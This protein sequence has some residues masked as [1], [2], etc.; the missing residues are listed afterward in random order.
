MAGN[1]TIR[2]NGGADWLEGSDG[3]DTID[4]G[5]GNDR[6]FGGYGNDVLTGGSGADRFA[7]R[8]SEYGQDRVTDF[9]FA[10][11]DRIDFGEHASVNGYA[12]LS[13]ASSPGGAII[14]YATSSG[15]SSITLDG[16]SVAS[17]TQEW[18]AF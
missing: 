13:I 15:Q 9:S 17:I 16:V 1:D 8:D 11:G 10:S 2:G 6:I 3:I 14:R 4:G 7:F 5:I 18:F 12:D